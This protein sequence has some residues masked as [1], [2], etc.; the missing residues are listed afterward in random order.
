M[1]C[2]VCVADSC[3]TLVLVVPTTSYYYYYIH[4]DRFYLD[5]TFYYMCLKCHYKFAI[6][7]PLFGKHNPHVCLYNFVQ[8]HILVFQFS[9]LITAEFQLYLNILDYS[10]LYILYTYS[11]YI[12]YL[13]LSY[14]CICM[15]SLCTHTQ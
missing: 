3:I 11:T 5:G 14:I 10:L 2:V 12:M 8:I 6:H 13:L 4:K 7:K 9:R 1:V 15:V